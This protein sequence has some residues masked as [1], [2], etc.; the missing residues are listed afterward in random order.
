MSTQK[1]DHHRVSCDEP[2]CPEAINLAAIDTSH[3]R[4]VLEVNKWWMAETGDIVHDEI[5]GA[6]FIGYAT[7]CPVH[8]MKV[9]S[10]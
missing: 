6:D 2:G 5:S 7:Y 9:V 3:M 10:R 4:K 8:K 1:M